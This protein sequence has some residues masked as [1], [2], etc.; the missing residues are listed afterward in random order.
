MTTSSAKS[1]SHRTIVLQA[2]P[3]SI[4]S[5]LLIFYDA[6]MIV[7]SSISLVD[8]FWGQ[9]I[10]VSFFVYSYLSGYVVP[11]SF[12]IG[13]SKKRKIFTSPL[14]I[15]ITISIPQSFIC[16][17]YVLQTL[18]HMISEPVIKIAHLETLH[19]FAMSFKIVLILF[20]LSG[21]LLILWSVNRKKSEMTMSSVKN[22]SHI[23]IVLQALPIAVY[24]FVSFY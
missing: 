17:A 15:A 4:Y 20:T 9:L 12:I 6:F 1:D 11:F 24:S 22:Q 14:A 13:N 18:S 19:M 21:Y 23:T 7:T 3:I 2:L 10:Y 5:L 16:V 8:D